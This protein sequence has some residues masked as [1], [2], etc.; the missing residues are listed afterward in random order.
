MLQNLAPNY[1]RAMLLK[2]KKYNKPYVLSGIYKAHNAKYEKER[3]TF[4]AVRPYVPGQE[5]INL[6]DHVHVFRENLDKMCPAWKKILKDGERYCLICYSKPYMSKYNEQRCS[7]RLTRD[8]GF[9][10]LIS[11]KVMDNIPEIFKEILKEECIDWISFEDGKYIVKEQPVLFS[12]SQTIQDNSRHRKKVEK[13]RNK[14]KKNK[15]RRQSI[16][17]VMQTKVS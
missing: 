6:F 17:R 2:A 9:M 8:I 16:W 4:T 5:T 3:I 13:E 11:Q 7:I 10:P 15:K 12:A 14:I 1:T